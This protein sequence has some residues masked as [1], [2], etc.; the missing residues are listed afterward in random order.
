MIVADRKKIA[1]IH[2]YKTGG[3]SITKLLMPHIS[4]NCRQ[5]N[6]RTS[7][8]NWRKTWHIDNSMHSKFSSALASVDSRKIDLDEYFK[9]TIVRNPY[10]WILSV[11][12]NFYQSPRGNSPKTLVNDFKFHLGRITNRK[13]F[14]AQYFYD[15]YPDGGFNNFILFLEYTIKSNPDLA[16]KIWGCSDQYSFIDNDRQIEF[17]FIGK[18]ETLESDLKT[19]FNKV[20]GQE[21]DVIPCETHGSDRNKQEREQ[22][23]KYYDETSIEIVNQIFARDF[24][25]F[26]Y[27]T[28]EDP[29]TTLPLL[30]IS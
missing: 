22:Y 18:F 4:E 24:Q 17:D 12:N 9:F 23:L 28:I 14:T 27:E 2:I 21:L 13:L 10:S 30:K 20:E 3:S 25:Y 1:Y 5:A 15:M 7:G 11:W 29:S 19:I 16:K 8:A 6:V 26:G